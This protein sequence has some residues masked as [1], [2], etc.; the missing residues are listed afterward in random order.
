MPQRAQLSVFETIQIQSRGIPTSYGVMTLTM[1][2]GQRHQF[3]II[4]GGFG[5]GAAPGMHDDRHPDP[6]LRAAYDIYAAQRGTGDRGM[7]AGGADFFIKV[8]SPASYGRG[9]TLAEIQSGE[10]GALGIHPD[11]DSYD[12][13]RPINGAAKIKP[14][15]RDNDG[16]NG[17]WGISSADAKRFQSLYFS[18]PENQRPTQLLVTPPPATGPVGL[19]LQL[20]NALTHFPNIGR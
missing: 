10:S 9:L 20:Q 1:P 11:G 15:G 8:S 4:S 13:R 2:D 6:R 7:K 18:L 3:N 14:D 19:M 16:T 5:R 12:L 17:C